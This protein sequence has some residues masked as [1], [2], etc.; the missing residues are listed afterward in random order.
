MCTFRTLLCSPAKPFFLKPPLIAETIAESLELMTTKKML[1]VVCFYL[2]PFPRYRAL[3]IGNCGR[4]YAIVGGATS[5]F[6]LHS[7]KKGLN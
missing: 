6:A 4:D 2:L 3:K 1:L 5:K 7:T